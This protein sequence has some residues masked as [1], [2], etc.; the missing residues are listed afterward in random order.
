M[1]LSG[2]TFCTACS[3]RANSDVTKPP[4]TV[5]PLSIVP[6]YP[7]ADTL[8][9]NAAQQGKLIGAA[10]NNDLVRQV[11]YAEVLAANTTCLPQ[12]MP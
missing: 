1:I 12:K 10:V 7:N 6:P 8:R 11:D 5:I 2:A 9:A 3:G 4:S